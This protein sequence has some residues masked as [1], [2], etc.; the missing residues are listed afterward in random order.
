MKSSYFLPRSRQTSNWTFVFYRA[1]K[2]ILTMSQTVLRF[3]QIG[4]SK[5]LNFYWTWNNPLKICMQEALW[6]TILRAIKHFLWEI[7]PQ[8]VCHSWCYIYDKYSKTGRMKERERD[9][10]KQT[11]CWISVEHTCNCVSIFK[12]RPM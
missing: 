11:G 12:A 5:E 9:W 10:N 3:A 8:N 7:K 6:K 1:W 4:N 2:E